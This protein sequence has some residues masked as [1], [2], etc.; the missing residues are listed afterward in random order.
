MITKFGPEVDNALEKLQPA[1]FCLSCFYGVHKETDRLTLP[2][3]VKKFT[4]PESFLKHIEK[5][6]VLDTLIILGMPD[7]LFKVKVNKEV[8]IRLFYKYDKMEFAELFK[9]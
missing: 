6:S 8:I 5:A 7:N 3:S 1:A 2:D 9:P 4:C